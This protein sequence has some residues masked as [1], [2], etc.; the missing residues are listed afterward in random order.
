MKMREVVEAMVETGRPSGKDVED[1]IL[2]LARVAIVDVRRLRRIVKEL[3]EDLAYEDA[4][5]S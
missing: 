2:F 5:A 1:T 4:P 3:N